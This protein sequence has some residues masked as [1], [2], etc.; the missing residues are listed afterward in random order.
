M[1]HLL[2]LQYRFSGVGAI[3][4]PN[5]PTEFRSFEGKIMHSAFWDN[6]YD[7][8]NKRVAVIGS[9]TRYVAQE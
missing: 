7:F 6:D 9:G 1:A 4:V 5:V 8:T 2:M 3:R